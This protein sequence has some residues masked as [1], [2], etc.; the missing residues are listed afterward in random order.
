MASPALIQVQGLRSGPQTVG[1]MLRLGIVVTNPATGA[2]VDPTTVVFK[3]IA[4]GERTATT[5][6]YGSGSAIV[7]ADTGVY[8]T[9]FT[10]ADEG[11]YSVRWEL[12]GNFIG[13]TE[14]K[15]TVAPSA[16]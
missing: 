10:L 1:D 3:S 2:E 12:G 4:P 7:K 15:I 13:A 5:L 11:V 14:F 9:N 16:F 8:H 6:T